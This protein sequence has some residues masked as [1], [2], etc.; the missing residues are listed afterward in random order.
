MSIIDVVKRL[1]RGERVE[2]DA[3]KSWDKLDCKGRINFITRVAARLKRMGFTPLYLHNGRADN[4][5][6]YFHLEK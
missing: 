2:I 4:G 3:P 1:A 5:Q 6:Y